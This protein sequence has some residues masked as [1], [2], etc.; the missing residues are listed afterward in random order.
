MCT[1]TF[2]DLGLSTSSSSPCQLA[3]TKCL[4]GCGRIVY[5]WTLR[6]QRSSGVRPLVG[7]TICRLLLFVSERTTCCLRQLFVTLE[8]PST[9]MSLCGLMCRVRCQDVCVTTAPQ[10]QT[11]SVRFCVPFA[12]RVAGLP[13]LT[14]AT[15]HSQARAS[16]PHKRWSKCTMEKVGGKFLQELKGKCINFLY[17]I[18]KNLYWHSSTV[19]TQTKLPV[20]SHSHQ[21]NS[22]STLTFLK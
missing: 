2:V 20:V 18:K 12:G 10:H 11:F 5:S 8:F 19:W 22:R 4:T 7:R 9:A 15:Q 13:R 6:K 21:V 17:K 16:T 14:T 3:W 1:Q